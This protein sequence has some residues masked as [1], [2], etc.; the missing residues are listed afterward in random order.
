VPGFPLP[1]LRRFS[2]C[3]SSLSLSAISGAWSPHP[4]IP[5]LADKALAGGCGFV[6]RAAACRELAKA[7]KAVRAL[8]L[9][10]KAALREIASKLL[11]DKRLDGSTAAAI[12]FV[13]KLEQLHQEGHIG[14]ADKE[15]LEVL[16]DAGSAAAHRGWEPDEEQ[17]RVLISI[18]E[19]FVTRFILKNEAGKLRG[20]IPVRQKRRN[21]EVPTQSENLIDFPVSK[22]PKDSRVADHE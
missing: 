1:V 10:R 3:G 13:K 4:K 22:T 7:V 11:K 16:T 17:L 6:E 2:L 18:M 15:C 20:S 12:S 14:R 19:H 8:L 5:F 21:L 9:E